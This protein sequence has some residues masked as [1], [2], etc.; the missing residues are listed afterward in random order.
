MLK[1]LR[2]DAGSVTIVVSAGTQS[3]FS[4]P[5]PVSIY[6]PQYFE[7]RG[8]TKFFIACTDSIIR[9]CKFIG[10]LGKHKFSAGL[11]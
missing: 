3:S 5:P 9:K 1:W 4:L 6:V 11:W 8:L 2:A 10:F 7:A